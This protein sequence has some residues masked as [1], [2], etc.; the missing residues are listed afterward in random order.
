[1]KDWIQKYSGGWQDLNCYSNESS[2]TTPIGFPKQF[3]ISR[4]RVKT[5]AVEKGN[6]NFRTKQC[7][8]YCRDSFD[9]PIELQ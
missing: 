3:I 8:D 9:I 7:A 6:N 1:M 5:G 4:L 2:Y